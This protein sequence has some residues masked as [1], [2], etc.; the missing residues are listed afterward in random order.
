[1]TSN[2]L[3]PSEDQEGKPLVRWRVLALQGESNAARRRE[4]ETNSEARPIRP[5]AV[6]SPSPHPLTPQQQPGGGGQEPCSLQGGGGRLLLWKESPTRP[7]GRTLRAFPRHVA[8]AGLEPRDAE[9]AG[10]PFLGGFRAQSPRTGSA[11]TF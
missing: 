8:T 2:T 9:W 11:F 5:S 3:T 7:P 10:P 1:M 6:L 4:P